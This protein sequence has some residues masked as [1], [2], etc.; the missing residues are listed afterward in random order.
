MEIRLQAIYKKQNLNLYILTMMRC[1]T[2]RY[3][4]FL[5]P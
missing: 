3:V 4:V 1:I 5:G 2:L